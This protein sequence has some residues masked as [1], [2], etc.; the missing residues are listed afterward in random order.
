MNDI[1]KRTL[2]QKC[3]DLGD[4]KRYLNQVWYSTKLPT[5]WNMPNLFNLKI[6]D[7][8]GRHLEFRKMLISTDMMKIFAPNFTR[9]YIKTTQI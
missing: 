7:G 5:C 2:A 3:I 1:I 6:S 8:D 4:C 9:R